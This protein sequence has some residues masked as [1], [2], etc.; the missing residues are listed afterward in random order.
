MDGFVELAAGENNI[1]I[2]L[3]SIGHQLIGFV[4]RFLRP[5]GQSIDSRLIHLRGRWWRSPPEG[6]SSIY[7]VRFF[8]KDQSF[9]YFLMLLGWFAVHWLSA[10]TNLVI[11]K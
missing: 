9:R 11:R 6:R 4:T 5:N 10:R 1:L 8:S 3:L 2:S 7:F